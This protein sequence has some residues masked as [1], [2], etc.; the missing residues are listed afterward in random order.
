MIGADFQG[1]V[2]THD[3]PDP[4]VFSV[5]E[6]TEVS[7]TT[8]LPLNRGGLET[9]QFGS[10][11]GNVGKITLQIRHRS[12]HF[13]N[14]VLILFVRLGLH[15]ISELDD[16]LELRLDFLFLQNK[17]LKLIEWRGGE[18]IKCPFRHRKWHRQRSSW[19]RQNAPCFAEGH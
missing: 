17:A 3:K 4:A 18:R 8:L 12:P 15:L 19:T 13:E 16:R 11:A 10:P 2:A 1:F 5:L 14:R 9:E 6:K 7:C